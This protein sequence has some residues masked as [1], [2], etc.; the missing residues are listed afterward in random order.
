MMRC[1]HLESG[2]LFVCG[3][4]YHALTAEVERLREHATET[5]RVSEALN[6]ALLDW[7]LGR[8][9][10]TEIG[11]WRYQLEMNAKRIKHDLE[12]GQG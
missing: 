1:N 4:C 10:A 5:V 9:P 2:G 11:A 12:G 6:K 7:D 8:V 3:E